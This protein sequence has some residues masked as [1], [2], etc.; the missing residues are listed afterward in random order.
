MLGYF[1][2]F[3]HLCTMKIDFWKYHGA[4]ND[5]IV[6][7]NR[8]QPFLLKE[9]DIAFLCDRHFGVGADGLIS[10][11]GSVTCDFCMTYFNADGKEGTMCGNGGRCVA[12]YYASVSPG[13]K[14]F[15]FEA[16][17]GLHQ[18]DILST[19]DNTTRV[20]LQMGDVAD[21][22]DR[23]DFLV[24][25]T[26]SPH[27]VKFVPDIQ[28]VDVMEEGKRIRWHRMFSPAGINVNFVQP[29]KDGLLLRTFERG[30]ENITLSCGT[31]TVAAAV[32]A[33][34]KG[35][36]SKSR[37]DVSSP[38]GTLQVE[39]TKTGGKYTDIRLTGPAVKVF[40]GSVELR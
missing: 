23:G 7:D 31:G 6:T 19:K 11:T 21:I 9:S 28:S 37:I 24:A 38:G 1:V 27:Y 4:G 26:G 8:L 40:N 39:F 3:C 22:T 32:C 29:L 12:A 5:F 34:Q 17:D 35:H 18:A 10:I 33:Y 25:D 2:S 14:K 20:A 16:I 15:V 30:V 13:K 36:I